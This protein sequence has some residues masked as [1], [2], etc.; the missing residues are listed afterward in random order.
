MIRT[1]R[2]TIEPDRDIQVDDAG[3]A[4]LKGQGLLLPGFEG[5]PYSGTIPTAKVP[6]TGTNE[7]KEG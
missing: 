4:D 1:V 5:E 2:T 7:N 3:Y 6:R